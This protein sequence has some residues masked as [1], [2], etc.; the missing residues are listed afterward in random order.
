MYKFEISADSPEE[1]RMKMQDFAKDFSPKLSTRPPDFIVQDSAPATVAQIA[2]VPEYADNPPEE[3]LPA[4]G[5]NVTNT[6]IA[7]SVHSNDKRDAKGLPWDSRIHSSS[8]ALNKD[9]T[10]RYKKGLDDGIKT[11]VEAQLRSLPSPSAVPVVA[12]VVV[13]TIPVELPNFASVAAPQVTPAV[14]QSPPLVAANP[15]GAPPVQAIPSK[16]E[17]VPLPPGQRPVHTLT[18]FS[19]N[20]FAGQM[21]VNQLINEG[22][23]TTEYIGQLTT[24]FK[25]G[26]FWEIIEPKNKSCLVE[27]YIMFKKC[28]FITDIEG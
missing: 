25:L 8:Q 16:Y 18:T 9:N 13:P 5:P 10:W 22:K 4:P 15:V 3:I 6:V 21:L 12:P 17:S 11:Q 27:L 28:G 23:L 7:P 1:L 20:L 24:H 14:Q 19:E 2:A 26:T